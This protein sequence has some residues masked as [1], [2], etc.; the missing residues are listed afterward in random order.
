MSLPELQAQI[1]AVSEDIERQKEVLRRLELNKSLLQR[2]V[3][4]ILD[5]IARLPVEISSKIFVERLHPFLYTPPPSGIQRIPTLL[6]QICHAWTDIA[7][8]TTSLWTKIHIVLPV[9][10]GFPAVLQG[11]LERAR[12]QPLHLHITIRF[13]RN[14][15]FDDGVSAVL[16]R[17]SGQLQCIDIH[18]AEHASMSHVPFESTQTDPMP[19]LQ[20]LRIKS[21]NNSVCDPS[22]LLQLLHRAP[23]LVELSLDFLHIRDATVDEIGAIVLPRLRR[24]YVA[25]IVAGEGGEIFQ[26]ITA[27]GIEYLALKF[28]S[29]LSN[30][31]LSFLKR[32]SPPLQNLAVD[33]AESP[34]PEF[35]DEL[36][37]LVPTLI[38]LDIGFPDP[39]LIER[40][41]TILA[42]TH[43]SRALPILQ[44]I[45]F[46][47]SAGDEI[48]DASWDHLL[49]ILVARRNEIRPCVS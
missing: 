12:D 25:R 7:L 48:S 15:A 8:S 5:P 6:L 1:S 18:L 26:F 49:P 38:R 28:V 22:T 46:Q 31:L 21:H 20:T 9:S 19:H 29:T 32:S 47:S 42:R 40:L 23:N 3:N 14:E 13:G 27:P 41:F 34:E 44:T 10:R 11:W 39:D 4:D 43:P 37:S 36:L 16:Q 35:L 2:Q 17:R 33:C 30:D 45:E 24:L